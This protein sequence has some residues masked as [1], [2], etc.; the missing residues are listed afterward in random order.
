VAV[1]RHDAERIERCAAAQHRADI[2]RIGDLVED[3]Q[4]GALGRV[5]Q[6]VAEPDVIVVSDMRRL[7]VFTV[8]RRPRS[9]YSRMGCSS[10]ESTAPVWTF[11]EGHI[12]SG[13]R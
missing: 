4:H 6:Q 7:S 1:L 5:G 10:I 9:K 13:I 2:V 3:Q 12:S 11:E 8:T